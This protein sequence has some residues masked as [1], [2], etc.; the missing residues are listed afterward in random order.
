MYGQL[1]IRATNVALTLTLGFPG[2]H[3][4][5]DALTLPLRF[6]GHLTTFAAFN[7]FFLPMLELLLPLS[8]V[9][10]LHYVG[11]INAP[12]LQMQLQWI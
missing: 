3:T 1:V 7:T 2:H 11:D 5:N 8:L 9:V 4:I 10:K 6:P 12:P